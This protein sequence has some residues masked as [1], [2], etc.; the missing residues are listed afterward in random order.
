[1]K[2][3]S[4]IVPIYNI[5]PYV[6]RCIRSLEVQNIPKIEYE[7]IC[8][9]DGSRDNSREI[10][11]K[12]QKEFDNIILIDQENQGVSVARNNGIDR[13]AGK[14][15][16][17]VDAD[18]YI[19]PNVLKERL[20]VCEKHD[21]DVGIC[22]YIILNETSKEEYRY[23]PGYDQENVLTGIDFFNRHE[24]GRSEIR[25]PHR[26][27]AIFLK[28]SFLN[29]HGL[30]YLPGVPYLEDGE[31]MARIT[32]LANKV[33]VL[34]GPIYLR[35]TI[36][37]SATQSRLFYSDKA[38]TGFLKSANNLL[39]F[40]LNYCRNEEQKVFMNQSIVHFTILFLTSMEG[41]KY[42]KKYSQLF[43]VLKKG[44]LNRLETEGCSTFYQKMGRYYNFS[45][46]S[47]YFNWMLFRFRRSLAN[48]L[49]KL[50]SF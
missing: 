4:V 35:T 41:F 45:I 18:D 29:S 39:Q 34:N 21:L 12:L 17:M 37:G 16:M 25:D 27:W 11:L 2:R 50:F 23:D 1:M 48:K 8:I 36:T 6:E 15:L 10:I 30:K 22:G 26:S 40:K 47:F 32:C 5:E 43:E 13:A 24:R 9:N 7:L 44:P 28:T 42:L 14:Y 3:L 31:L 33:S 38:R 19:S 46:H 49:G 20:D